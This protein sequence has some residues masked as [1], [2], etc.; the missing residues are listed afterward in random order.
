MQQ[1]LPGMLQAFFLLFKVGWQEERIEF[2]VDAHARL[3]FGSHETSPIIWILDSQARTRV[4]SS[5]KTGKRQTVSGVVCLAC[6]C[7]FK[8]FPRDLLAKKYCD[9]WTVNL[10]LSLKL[11]GP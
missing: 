3:L 5:E 6:P 2:Y 4:K 9:R 10:C 11:F 7:F 1:P 8:S